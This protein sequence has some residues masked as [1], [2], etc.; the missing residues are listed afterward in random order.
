[1]GISGQSHA[2]A[3]L[4]PQRKD[5][6][7]R[8]LGGWV[9]PRAGLDAEARGKILCLCCNPTPVVQSIIRLYT[10]GATL[11]LNDPHTKQFLLKI[12]II[13][14]VIKQWGFHQA[15]VICFILSR[16]ILPNYTRM[17]SYTM[18]LYPSVSVTD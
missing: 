5:P 2:Q 8:W 1:M 14:F 9:G 17:F 18:D 11:A 13:K 16:S 15:P 12:H 3:A 10:D 4:Y 6:G 7:T